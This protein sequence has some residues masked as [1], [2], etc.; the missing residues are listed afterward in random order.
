MNSRLR[1]LIFAG[2]ST[3]ANTPACGPAQR[4]ASSAIDEI[5][6]RHADPSARRR[7]AARTGRWRS[8]T[9]VASPRLRR[10]RGDPAGSVVT[11][12]PSS[13]RRGDDRVLLVRRD[14]LVGADGEVVELDRGRPLAQRL[15]ER[16]TATGTRTSAR[17]A[18]I[19]SCRKRADER[20]AG[21]AGHDELAAIRSP[22]VPARS[23]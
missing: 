20:L 12:T 8:T 7:S 18:A 14:R 22:R 23:P 17:C 4:C 1:A 21:A 19:A 11:G 13:R 16:A 9:F 5:E 3:V 2:S 15:P 10:K 6:G